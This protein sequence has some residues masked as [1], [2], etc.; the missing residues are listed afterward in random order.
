[1][2]DFSGLDNVHLTETRI[3]LGNIA[4][5]LRGVRELAEAA[6]IAGTPTGIDENIEAALRTIEVT[7]NVVMEEQSRRGMGP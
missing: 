3:R 5:Q 7:M 4:T 6:T 1:M 2:I